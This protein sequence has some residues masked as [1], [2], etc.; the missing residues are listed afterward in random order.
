MI[1]LKVLGGIAA[2]IV[3]GIVVFGIG[4]RRWTRHLTRKQ[5]LDMDDLDIGMLCFAWP[6]VLLAFGFMGLSLMAGGIVKRIDTIGRKDPGT[7]GD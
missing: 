7:Y 4:H 2:Y 3:I 1:V 6:V 5:I